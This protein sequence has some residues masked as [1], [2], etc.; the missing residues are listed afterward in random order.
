MGSHGLL[1]A[2]LLS[3]LARKAG[4]DKEVRAAWRALSSDHPAPEGVGRDK[5]R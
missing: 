4:P 5:A 3:R 2:H 1:W